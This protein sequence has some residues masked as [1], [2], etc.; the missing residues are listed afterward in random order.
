MPSLASETGYN[1]TVVTQV[2]VEDA[3]QLKPANQHSQVAALRPTQREMS[4]GHLVG[5]G[6]FQGGKLQL[7]AED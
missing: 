1:G 4:P 5:W 3:Y 7:A 2:R 6:L